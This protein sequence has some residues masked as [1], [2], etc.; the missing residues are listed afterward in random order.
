MEIAGHHDRNGRDRRYGDELVV[1]EVN[2]NAKCISVKLQ[3][4]IE[5]DRN[6]YSFN[7]FYNCVQ[8]DFENWSEIFST[9]L[10][11]NSN[12]L[13]AVSAV[14]VIIPVTRGIISQLGLQIG[15]LQSQRAKSMWVGWSFSPEIY[16]GL[17]WHELTR[18]QR[19]NT[20]TGK[21]SW[22]LFPLS[23]RH[24]FCGSNF[25][26]PFISIFLVI[27]DINSRVGGGEEGGRLGNTQSHI[28]M[29]PWAAAL[30]RSC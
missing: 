11:K 2:S 15:T 13:V 7:H 10:G 5:G 12:S 17:A 30:G 29:S 28:T 26:L 25:P 21:E 19:G 4:V 22:N 27:L 16:A 20:Y 23:K 24:T 9:S 18:L 14:E 1:A 8:R 6:R 3:T